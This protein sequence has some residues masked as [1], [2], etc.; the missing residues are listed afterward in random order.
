[1]D[2]RPVRAPV[3]RPPLVKCDRCG[4]H[5]ANSFIKISHHQ[6]V[7]SRKM[8]NFAP[9]PHFE[10][11]YKTLCMFCDCEYNLPY[12]WFM[13]HT[14]MC[15]RIKK[16]LQRTFYDVMIERIIESQSQQVGRRKG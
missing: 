1:M 10:P 2:H 4:A 7:C 14:Y 16:G 11:R 9:L 6:K 8:E 13:R 3:D 5:V 12:T 15:S